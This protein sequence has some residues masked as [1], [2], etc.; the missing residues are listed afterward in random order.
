MSAKSVICLCKIAEYLTNYVW[1]EA[2]IEAHPIESLSQEWTGKN[3]TELFIAKR[4]KYEEVF[5]P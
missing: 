2:E 5:L 1:T 4:P 3:G